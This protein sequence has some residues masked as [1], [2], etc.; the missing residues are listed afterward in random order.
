MSSVGIT[1][2]TIGTELQNYCEKLGMGDGAR[3]ARLS[4][5]GLG[6]A[7]I[8]LNQYLHDK[9]IV[10]HVDDMVA[11]M[12]RLLHADKQF[13]HIMAKG[14]KLEQLKVTLREYFLS[15][16]KHFEDQNYFE[17][18]LRIGMV[19]IWV[20]VNLPLYQ[21]AYRIMQQLLI[22]A[23]PENA[24]KRDL[25]IAHI[26][27]ITTLDMSLAIQAYHG[28][29]VGGLLESLNAQK[30]LNE[31][32]EERVSHD[33]L[34]GVLSRTSFM[35]TLRLAM[36]TLNET[37]KPFCLAMM[38]FDHFKK[39]NDT[40]GHVSGDKVLSE[41]PKRIA[42]ALRDHDAIGRYGGEEF[43]V[44]LSSVDLSQGVE[45]AERLRLRV[46]NNPIHTHEGKDISV[47]VS[48]GV[49][50]A[51]AGESIQEVLERADQALYQAKQAGRNRVEINDVIGR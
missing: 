33:A 27:K 19:H 30:Q 10:P 41:V 7:D 13:Q 24:D 40:F 31:E 32:L 2:I 29:Q 11:Q 42:G 48:I 47:T 39:I 38:D 3:K 43:V 37:P 49:T 22:D 34:T 12:Y 36:L 5:L 14:Y 46:A 9:V 26:L 1:I 50:E 16:G 20:G 28:A 25:L 45:V 21:C 4:L 51:H 6:T 15:L 35:D 44:L 17:S 23:I 18:R 8:A